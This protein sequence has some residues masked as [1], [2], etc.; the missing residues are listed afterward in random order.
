MSTYARPRKL[1]QKGGGAQTTTHETTQI[2]KGNDLI[3]VYAKD[4]C[5][6]CRA[7][8]QFLTKHGL[9]FE[10]KD[11]TVDTEWQDILPEAKMAPIVVTPNDAW[12]GFRFD[13]LKGLLTND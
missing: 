7:T 12:F 10:S 5:Q 1:A 3:K 6:M 8:E 13:L 9:T 4:N 2:T 11:I